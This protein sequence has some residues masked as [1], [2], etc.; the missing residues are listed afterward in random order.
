LIISAHNGIILPAATRGL[1]GMKKLAQFTIRQKLASGLALMFLS[2][3]IISLYAIIQLNRLDRLITTALAVDAEILKGSESLLN[4]LLAQAGNEKKFIITRDAAFKKLFIDSVRESLARLDALAALSDNSKTT[5]ML[6]AIRASYQRY[7]D[8][9]EREFAAAGTVPAAGGS[10]TLVDDLSA[11]IRALNEAAQRSL[12]NTML[13]S[14]KISEGGTGIALFITVFAILCGVAFG[15]IITKAFYIPLQRLKQGTRDIARGDFLKK[16]EISSADE[17]GDVSAS[18]N[19]MCDR[20]RE[21]DQLKTDFISNITHDLKTPLASITEANNLLAEGIGG[22][23]SPEQQ[24]LLAIIRED[25]AR[26]LRLIESIIDLSKMESGLLTYEFVPSDIAAVI[27]EAI[28]AVRML[29]E[30]K[31]ITVSFAPDPGLPRAAIDRAKLVQGLINLLGNAIKFTQENGSVHVSARVVDGEQYLVKS[32][33]LSADSD[34]P[35]ADKRF[36]EITVADTG[37]GIPPED[38]PR[39][40]D[41]FYQGRA[42]VHQRGSGLGLAIVKHIIEDHGGVIRAQSA[43]AGGSTFHILLPLAQGAAP[44]GI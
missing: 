3:L 39:I 44:A 33:K 5:D 35:A 10:Q 29:A 4:A 32:K 26:L 22:S 20:L 14:K 43:A 7:A 8:L 36:F 40:F 18:F 41:K 17:I 27:T 28:D 30:R 19:Q 6:G 38:L 37:V 16:I 1:A 34:S 23:P 11:R 24:H 21:L 13:S 9:A 25:A 12:D 2:V 42:G 15:F 31:K